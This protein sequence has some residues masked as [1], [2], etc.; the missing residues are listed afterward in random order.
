MRPVLAALAACLLFLP[1]VAGAAL[2]Y[3]GNW[4]GSYTDPQDQ[5]GDLAG[6]DIKTISYAS[7]GAYYYFQMEMYGD[8]VGGADYY[9]I[10]INNGALPT[11]RNW[12]TN[13]TYYVGFIGD[14]W[15]TT[16]TS[17]SVVIADKGQD[18][19]ILQWKVQITGLASAFSWWGVTQKDDGIHDVDIAVTPIP[20]TAML[21]GSGLVGLVG[22]RRR[23]RTQA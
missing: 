10:Y 17:G 19:N 5:S 7:D 14:D 20:A 1:S 8:S 4:A 9:G 21:L 13:S 6:M 2:I 12:Y 3:T 22:L 16:E 18:G 15:T 11:G 23:S